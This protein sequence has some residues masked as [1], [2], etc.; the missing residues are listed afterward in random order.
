M[1]LRAKANGSFCLYLAKADLVRV[2]RREG[3]E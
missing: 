1:F 2:R 3:K